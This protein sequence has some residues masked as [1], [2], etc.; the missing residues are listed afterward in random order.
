MMSELYH[1]GVKGM[2][3]GVRKD[4]F[5]QTVNKTMGAFLG[6]ENKHLNKALRSSGKLRKAYLNAQMLG[7][8]AGKNGKNKYVSKKEDHD[9]YLRQQSAARRAK[10]YANEFLEKYKTKPMSYLESIN[11]QKGAAIGTAAGIAVPIILPLWATIPA[12][13]YIGS[14]IGGSSMKHSDDELMHYGVKGMKWHKHIYA[15]DEPPKSKHGKQANTST[16]TG[17]RTYNPFQ[18]FRNAA[19]DMVNNAQ[20]T[21]DRSQALA[22]SVSQMF[23]DGNYIGAISTAKHA[24]QTDAGVRS[25]LDGVIDSYISDFDKAGSDWRSIIF[26]NVLRTAHSV[27][28]HALPLYQQGSYVNGRPKGRRTINGA[29]TVT[30]RRH[31]GGGSRG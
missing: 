16:K 7:V 14:R 31:G 18:Y 5:K 20:Q 10:R 21:T 13:Y 11:A 22:D 3:W 1:Y 6:I 17:N 23:N 24:Y 27:G 19:S 30:N 28:S 26:A 15:N 12:G 29:N 2:K 9:L 8:K 4:R 25:V